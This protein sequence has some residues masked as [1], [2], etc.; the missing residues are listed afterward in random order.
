MYDRRAETDPLPAAAQR[1]LDVCARVQQVDVDGAV[2]ARRR[3]RAD[4]DVDD[5]G[6]D[7]AVGDAEV[8]REKVDAIDHSDASTP[9]PIRK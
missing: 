5:A 8:A 9:G 3:R 1:P 7:T 2:H 6:G 4:A